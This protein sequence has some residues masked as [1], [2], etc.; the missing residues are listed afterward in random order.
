[1]SCGV[2]EPKNHVHG[3]L[4]LAAS[5]NSSQC[6][7]HQKELHRCPYRIK[8]LNHDRVAFAGLQ[9]TRVAHFGREGDVC[10]LKGYRPQDLRSF[11]FNVCPVPV[12]VG[13]H[14]GEMVGVAV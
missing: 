1:M 8:G 7:F 12:V 11:I 13:S 14:S 9:D 4:Q 5:E 2:V 3:G 10:M 6:P